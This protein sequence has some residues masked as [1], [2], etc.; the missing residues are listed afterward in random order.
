MPG[1]RGRG[2]ALSFRLLGPGALRLLATPA[3]RAVLTK[4]RSEWSYWEERGREEGEL[5]NSWY[6]WA[7][8]GA[9]GLTPEAYR[10]KRLLDVGCG[11]RGSLEWAHE[12]A[13]RVGVDPLARA[14]R[15]LNG[16]RHAMRYVEARAERLPFP[17][18]AFDVVSSFNALDHVEDVGAAI[19]ELAR[20]VAPGGRL[21]VLVEIGHAPTEAEPHTLDWDVLRDLG[22]DFRTLSEKHVE[23]RARSMY[24]DLSDPV[25]FDH[26]DRSPRPGWLLAHLVRRTV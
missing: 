4:R 20:V 23:Q 18:G 7:F 13:E 11:P 15:R 22:P 8:T 14:Y 17:D 21:L 16:D 19:A 9:F 6:A 12:A 1:L 26:A 2:Y 5:Q 24:A 3:G 10:G 25:A